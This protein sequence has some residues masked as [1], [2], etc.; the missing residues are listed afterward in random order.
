MEISTRQKLFFFFSFKVKLNP[1]IRFIYGA[2]I[3]QVYDTFNYLGFVFT[4]TGSF[5]NAIKTLSGKGQKRLGALINMTRE[6]VIPVNIMLDLF[7]SFVSSTL[8]YVY[9]IGRLQTPIT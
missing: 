6:M 8:N 4:K 9:E 2:E 3:L 5:L 7:D 1:N